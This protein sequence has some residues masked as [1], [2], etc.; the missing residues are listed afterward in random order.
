MERKG[1]EMGTLVE[2]RIIIDVTILLRTQ[3]VTGIQRVVRN[4]VLEMLKLKEER[5]DLIAYS[6]KDDCFYRIDKKKFQQHYGIKEGINKTILFTKERYDLDALNEDYLLYDLDAVW[7]SPYPRMELYPRLKEKG[8]G[9]VVFVHDLIPIYYPDYCDNASTNQFMGYIGATIQYAD[10]IITSTQS[11]LD[12]INELCQSIGIEKVKGGYS[13]LGSDFKDRAND[14]VDKDIQAAIEGKKYILSVGTIEPRKNGLFL[15]DALEEK[16]ADE[17]IAL[18]FVGA[19][20]WKADAIMERINEHPLKD[21]LLFH[22]RGVSDASLKYLY[23]HALC[24]AFPSY[25]EGFGLPI[26]EAFERGTP[27]IASDRPV[28]MEVGKGLAEHFPLNDIEAF[29]KLVL[30]YANDET[31]R[32]SRKEKIKKE[33]ERYSW[34]DTSQKMLELLDTVESKKKEDHHFHLE[35]YGNEAYWKYARAYQKQYGETP[36][37]AIDYH[38]GKLEVDIPSF[39]TKEAV[40]IPIICGSCNDVIVKVNEKDE[41]SLEENT[42]SMIHLSDKDE[43][44]YFHIYGEGQEVIRKVKRK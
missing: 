38:E 32:E 19:I 17:N 4:V 40:E 1:E 27:V 25:E 5:I 36:M 9:V 23:E 41:Y 2:R 7:T 42:I 10:Y 15:I 8:V 34:Q 44:S 43:Y 3:R 28:L 24:V 31:Y 30:Q 16:L 39:I 35:D 12:S 14:E 18:V 37:I 22:F 11:V 20:G 29:S 13:W 33:Y 21:K 6:T 26:I